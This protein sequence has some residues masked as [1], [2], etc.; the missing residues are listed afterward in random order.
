VA[1]GIGAIVAHLVAM[2]KGSR[3]GELRDEGDQWGEKTGA[4][5]EKTLLPYLTSYYSS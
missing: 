5:H 1:S 3:V 2:A 4:L